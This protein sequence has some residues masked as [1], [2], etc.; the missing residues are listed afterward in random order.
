MP[1]PQICKWRF[2]TTTWLE[3]EAESIGQLSTVFKDAC[4]SSSS[5]M[6]SQLSVRSSFWHIIK[7]LGAPTQKATRFRDPLCSPC[8]AYTVTASLTD[9]TLSHHNTDGPAALEASLSQIAAQTPAGSQGPFRAS[10]R[11]VQRSQERNG[12]ETRDLHPPARKSPIQRRA[13]EIIRDELNQPHARLGRLLTAKDSL[14]GDAL[15]TPWLKTLRLLG[16]ATPRG[17]Q[18]HTKV[19]ETA[20]LPNRMRAKFVK[21]STSCITDILLRTNS[22]VEIVHPSTLDQGIGEPFRGTFTT[23]R[24]L[25]T[26]QENADAMGVLPQYLQFESDLSENEQSEAWFEDNARHEG[27]HVIQPGFGKKPL[28]TPLQQ[29]PAYPLLT[30]RP[31]SRKVYL[32]TKAADERDLV[33]R[34]SARPH[35]WSVTAMAEYVASLTRPSLPSV[36]SKYKVGKGNGEFYGRFHTTISEELEKL[37]LDD[38]LRPYV[39]AE[40]LEVAFQFLSR[41]NAYAAMGRIIQSLETDPDS[42]RPTVSTMN[43]ILAATAK[44]QS[45]TQFHYFVNVMLRKGVTPDWKTWTHFHGLVMQSLGNADDAELVFQCIKDIGVLANYRAARLVAEDSMNYNMSRHFVSPDASLVEF[46]RLQDARFSPAQTVSLGSARPVSAHPWL[47]ANGATRMIKFLLK[48]GRLEDAYT[49]VEEMESCGEK[50]T[51]S[52]INTFLANAR[53]FRSTNRLLD[54]LRFFDSRDAH[55]KNVTFKLNPP[56]DATY[57]ILFRMAWEGQ[58][59]NLMRVLWRRCCLDG[60]VTFQRRFDLTQSVMSYPPDGTQQSKTEWRSRVFKYFAGKFALGLS[61]DLLRFGVFKKI[62]PG[63]RLEEIADG[64]AI[65]DSPND[66]TSA[67]AGDLRV[68]RHGARKRLLWE[69][70]SADVECAGQDVAMQP[71]GDALRDAVAKDVAWRKD[72]FGPWNVELQVSPKGVV[73][74]VEPLGDLEDRLEELIR[75]GVAVPLQG[76]ID[77]LV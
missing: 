62:D 4:W 20:H 22:Q 60:Y 14:G 27:S 31:L 44:H 47:T 69:A 64:A 29:P 41:H 45:W 52:I 74:P 11:Y 61:D 71:F 77:S 25:G 49:V 67:Q 40:A 3:F 35:A 9:H 18:H 16:A 32:P 70:I 26:H 30:S 43:A 46:W 73:A 56:N 51:I 5:S 15:W 28:I 6:I 38:D 19:I 36:R 63:N 10:D 75:D 58:N 48:L 23:V 39:S 57:D 59:A 66:Y 33:D 54:T 24:L 50:V 8:R 42:P 17:L 2:S 76:S 21:D 65:T 7:S 72:G 1:Q 68:E 34:L 53:N 55:G 12:R 37:F 13:N